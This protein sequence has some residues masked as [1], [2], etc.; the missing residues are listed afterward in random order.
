[1]AKRYVSV[2]SAKRRSGQRGG[3]DEYDATEDEDEAGE[4]G[5]DSK[6][7]LL[8]IS[9]D[10]YP[11]RKFDHPFAAEPLNATAKCDDDAA[12][13]VDKSHY[14]AVIAN[15]SEKL[16]AAALERFKAGQVVEQSEFRLIVLEALEE[17]LAGE[18]YFQSKPLPVVQQRRKT[19]Y[20]L[21]PRGLGEMALMPEHFLFDASPTDQELV[22]IYQGREGVGFA[23]LL[24]STDI[25]ARFLSLAVATACVTAD[26]KNGSSFQSKKWIDDF[27]AKLADFQIPVA[28]RQLLVTISPDAKPPFINLRE[29][30]DRFDP[31]GKHIG[32]M[33]HF[34]AWETHLPAHYVDNVKTQQFLEWAEDVRERI[35]A[36]DLSFDAARELI[37]REREGAPWRQGKSEEDVMMENLATHF[38]E[39]KV[40]TPIHVILHERIAS[41]THPSS[42]GS[43]ARVASPA[44]RRRIFLEQAKFIKTYR[45][46]SETRYVLECHYTGAEL[47]NIAQPK[48]DADFADTVLNHLGCVSMDHVRQM[49]FV[50]DGDQNV[51]VTMNAIPNLVPTSWSL[52][53]LKHRYQPF[54]F[55]LVCLAIRDDLD[56]ATHFFGVL[57]GNEHLV[58]GVE[59]LAEISLASFEASCYPCPDIFDFSTKNRSWLDSFADR[60]LESMIQEYAQA[61]DGEQLELDQ[62]MP[63]RP[64]RNLLPNGTM[65]VKRA[66]FRSVSEQLDEGALL[67]FLDRAYYFQKLG[68]QFQKTADGVLALSMN[69]SE[70]IDDIIMATQASM[71]TAQAKCAHTVYANAFCYLV[72]WILQKRPT[73]PVP[74]KPQIYVFFD[75]VTPLLPILPQASSKSAFLPSVCQHD[76]RQEHRHGFSD[77]HISSLTFG[78][79]SCDR[80]TWRYASWAANCADAFGRVDGDTPASNRELLRSELRGDGQTTGVQG[81]EWVFGDFTSNGEEQMKALMTKIDEVCAKRPQAPSLSTYDYL[82][83]FSPPLPPRQDL[84]SM[85]NLPLPQDLPPLPPLPPRQNLPL[86]K[87]PAPEYL[88]PLPPLS[89]LPLLPPVPP[90]RDCDTD[91]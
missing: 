79:W 38:P 34:D 56:A 59:R 80:N 70:S 68:I 15:V 29:G 85:Q 52:N 23:G 6:D 60:E 58:K 50:D 26:Q 1:M 41:A 83:R 8:R 46:G 54:P 3:E 87:L 55:A 16:E 73:S 57:E 49:A 39:I 44:H 33:I 69:A 18:Y 81:G 75:P 5:D 72:W 61:H 77:E 43:D 67:G 9:L 36:S 48:S 91:S 22:A 30:N 62:Y 28:P 13:Q 65:S 74:A 76:S 7:G 89:P 32:R 88:P 90:R 47:V 4:D 78:K 25:C 42:S 51:A 17:E 24:R 27:N 64:G 12:F 45:D 11:R 84:P 66:S 63:I 2:W 10:A 19:Y 14:S 20:A 21:L 31:D 53:I 40:W 71:A 86:H 37:T 82:F 35:G